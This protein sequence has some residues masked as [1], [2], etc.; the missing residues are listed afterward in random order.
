MFLMGALLVASLV[1]AAVG[2]VV[3][4]ILLS[5]PP[6]P[7]P[8]T[9]ALVA[10]ILASSAVAVYCYGWFSV[11]MGGPFPELCTSRND[12][13]ADLAV[14]K[15]QYWPLR[16][17]CVYSDGSTVEYVSMSVTVF[18]CLLAGAASV[19]VG[20]SVYLRKRVRRTSGV[21]S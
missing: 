21:L 4:L 14:I 19:L 15:Q 12:V 3:V 2:V 8:R 7:G 18:V 1:T 5:H 11:N 16:N 9:Y 6:L 13:G 10:L 17:A 20:T